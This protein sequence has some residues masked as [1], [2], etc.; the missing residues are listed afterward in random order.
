MNKLR[1]LFS[2]MNQTKWV[3][4]MTGS[5]CLVI[6]TCWLISENALTPKERIERAFSKHE[7]FPVTFHWVEQ[8]EQCG[9]RFYGTYNGCDVFFYQGEVVLGVETTIAVGDYRFFNGSGF[10][11]YVHKNGKILDL[12]DAYKQGLIS[13]GSLELIYAE[14]EAWYDWGR[15]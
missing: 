8:G 5:L 4:V 14:H 1:K 6:L 12:A 7:G 15:P 9:A 11:L 2:K 13:D 3:L 10:G